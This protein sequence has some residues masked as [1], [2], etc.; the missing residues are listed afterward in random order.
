MTLAF[1]TLGLPSCV[2]ALKKKC[3]ETNW[4]E[5]G[6]QISK[7][8]QRIDDDTFVKQCERENAEI[9]Q[10]DLD[11]GFKKGM[12][13][14][15]V[16]DYAFLV[17][18]RGDFLSLDFCDTQVHTMMKKRHA[19]G[20]VEFCKKENGYP[21]GASGTKYNQVCP[22]AL[23]GA[24]LPEYKR[25]R[26]DYLLLVIAQKTKESLQLEQDAQRREG[27]LSHV[28]SQLAFMDHRLNLAQQEYLPQEEKTRKISDIQM[29]MSDL[30]FKQSDL[31]RKTSEGRSKSHSLLD[32]VRELEKEA[33]SLN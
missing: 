13:E 25:G 21:F 28:R 15:C 10:G 12:E 6:S 16:P 22:P 9:H 29:Q 30:R 33:L 5:Y 1:L 31:E 18:K 7:R 27:D 19:E 17:G 26:K 4:F 32:E 11:K 2:S 3:N 23:E 20:V 24:F 8:G 14:Y